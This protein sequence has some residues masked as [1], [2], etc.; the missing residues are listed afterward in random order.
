MLGIEKEKLNTAY[1]EVAD[2]NEMPS[3]VVMMKLAELKLRINSYEIVN[4][5]IIKIIHEIWPMKEKF[6]KNKKLL[7]ELSLNKE[8]TDNVILNKL[9]ELFKQFLYKFGY[10][11][12]YEQNV[13]LLFDE[14]NSNYLYLPQARVDQYEEHLRSCL[15]Y[16][17]DAA[18]D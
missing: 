2:N 6:D 18:D 5:Q 16:T 15:L 11:S 3:E 8:E 4:Q 12:N 9:Q 1:A 10:K 17:S 7:A 13:S 14:K